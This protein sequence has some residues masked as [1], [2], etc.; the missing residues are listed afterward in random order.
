MPLALL[1]RLSRAFFAHL[2]TLWAELDDLNRDRISSSRHQ[3]S[4]S[5][6]DDE[7]SDTDNA[8][9][10]AS[11]RNSRGNSKPSGKE[12][13][14]GNAISDTEI[15]A[16]FLDAFDESASQTMGSTAPPPPPPPSFSALLERALSERAT[17]SALQAI[18]EKARTPTALQTQAA[19]GRIYTTER[20]MQLNLFPP[21]PNGEELEALSAPNKGAVRELQE[22]CRHNATMIQGVYKITEALMSGVAR[23]TLSQICADLLTYGFG[24]HGALL[25]RI[26]SIVKSSI[27][28]HF[29]PLDDFRYPDSLQLQ[30]MEVLTEQER[31]DARKE[32]QRL[33]QLRRAKSQTGPKPAGRPTPQG[34][35]PQHKRGR[36]SSSGGGGGGHRA[37]PKRHESG[38]DFFARGDQK[39]SKE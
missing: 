4:H 39:Q 28:S 24:A 3:R 29:T 19:F 30:A 8:A 12:R 27:S 17:A 10:A 32:R 2:R 21:K 18:V 5:H 22:A 16:S 6:D 26:K 25:S 23:E 31:K 37:P 36:D 1:T 9:F 33:E 35:E 14:S 15:D 20:M 34:S 38:G 7:A 13:P 11:R